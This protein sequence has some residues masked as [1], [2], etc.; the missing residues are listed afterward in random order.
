MIADLFVNQGKLPTALYQI[1]DNEAQRFI[2]KCLAPATERLS[3]RDIL[4]DPFL[5]SVDEK[6]LHTKIIGN[7]NSLRK[8]KLVDSLPRTN[9]TI[10][11][12]LKP[13]D[14]TVILKVQFSEANGMGKNL[15]IHY[16]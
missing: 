2:K 15:I 4:L 13:K 9:M 6:L 3:A 5:S 8:L 14:G 12:K 16:K 10:T 1:Q 11:G 7:E